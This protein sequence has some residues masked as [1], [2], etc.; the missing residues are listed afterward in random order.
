MFEMSFLQKDI[1]EYDGLESIHGATYQNERLIGKTVIVSFND[2]KIEL[3]EKRVLLLLIQ[4][5]LFLYFI[6]CVIQL[7]LIY[8]NRKFKSKNIII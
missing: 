3:Q 7:I 4:S 6:F 5:L 1:K 2:N 8:E